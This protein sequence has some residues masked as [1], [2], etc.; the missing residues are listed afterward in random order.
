MAKSIFIG[1]KGA[2]WAV[3]LTKFKKKMYCKPTNE[4]CHVLP[5]LH[6]SKSSLLFYLISHLQLQPAHSPGSHLICD[7]S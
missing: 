5:S 3:Q 1:E 2:P 7:Q 4:F 6:E